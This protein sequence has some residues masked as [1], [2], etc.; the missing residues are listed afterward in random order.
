M[1]RSRPKRFDNINRR[2]DNR[3]DRTLDVGPAPVTPSATGI[4]YDE[5]YYA[6]MIICVPL[7]L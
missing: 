5:S 3:A 7:F 6:S 4:R 1:E 2:I